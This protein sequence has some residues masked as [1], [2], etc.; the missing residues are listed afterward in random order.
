MYL[1]TVSTLFL[2][3]PLL[4]SASSIGSLTITRPLSQQYPPVGRVDQ[5]F[6]WTFSN[7]TFSPSNDLTYTAFNLPSWLSF[8]GSTCTFTGKPTSDDIGNNRLV[9]ITAT[10]IDG[11][12]TISD[13]IDLLVSEHENKIQIGHAISDQLFGNNTSTS[14]TPSKIASAYPYNNV[15]PYYPGV[16]VP[17]NWSFSLGFT[18]STFTAPTRVFYSASLI[19]GSPLPDWLVFNNQTVTFDGVSPPDS[20]GQIYRIILSGSDTFDYSDIQQSF[21]VVISSHDIQQTTNMVINMTIGY[22]GEVGLKNIL[23]NSL[24]LNGQQSFD[25]SELSNIQVDTTGNGWLTYHS[26]NMSISGTPSSNQQ[27]I[28]L[29]ISITDKYDDILNTTIQVALFPS[30]FKDDKPDPMIIEVGKLNNISLTQFLSNSTLDNINITTTFD[31]KDAGSWLSLSPDQKSLSGIPPDDTSYDSV[32]AMLHA[33]DLTTNAYSKSVL[34]FSLFSN[35]TWISHT[36]PHQ[37][38]HGLSK[39]TQVAIGIVCSLVGALLLGFLLLQCRRRRASSALA[40]GMEDGQYT[41]SPIPEEGKWS[42][43]AA[44]T[45]ALEYVEKMG[46]DPATAQ[47]LVLGRIDGG[48]SETVVNTVPHLRSASGASSTS[49]KVKKSFLSNPF[50]KGNKR[51]LPKISNPIIMPSLSNAAFQAQLAAAVDKAGIVDRSQTTYSTSTQSDHNDH[52]QDHDRSQSESEFTATPSYI[53]AS[54]IDRSSNNGSKLSQR[55]DM[56]GDQS[57]LSIDRSTTLTDDSKFN[58]GNTTRSGQSSR[59]SWESEPPFIWTTGDTPHNNQDGNSSFR[60]SSRSSSRTNETRN[61]I[62]STTIDPNAPTQRSDFKITNIPIIHSSKSLNKNVLMTRSNSPIDSLNDNEGISIDN[63]HFPTDSDLAHTETS[64]LSGD[65]PNSGVIIQTASRVDARRTLDSPAAASLASSHTER[66]APSPVMTTHS[67]LVSFGKQRNVQVEQGKGSMSHSAVIEAGSIGLGIG[68]G[69]SH[70]VANAN[71]ASHNQTPPTIIRK[72]HTPS[73]PPESPLPQPP[74]KAITRPRQSGSSSSSRSPTP[75]TSLPSLPAL[76]TLPSTTSTASKK[77]KPR[78]ASP[79][80]SPQRI[81]LGVLEPFHFYPPLSIS[82]SNSTS[83]T[84]SSIRSGDV[85]YLAFVE[86]KSTSQRKST[87]LVDLPDWLHFEDGELWGVPKQQDRGEVDIRI[88]E[89]RGETERV[90]GR[91]SLEVVGR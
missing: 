86:K 19:D 56:T 80:A 68:I 14:S 63:I 61:S 59:A 32:S 18:P 13:Y 42:Y 33:Q 79:L 10:T 39:G 87:E 47:M 2:F 77:S 81:L 20:N 64:S 66:G 83:T 24:T 34:T 69:I 58:G 55:S 16:R 70:V 57:L 29:P 1:S 50:A 36:H 9:Q 71:G 74:I 31:P 3:L 73:P 17:P 28:A 53:S 4:I 46:G 65:D 38:S 5:S 45:P 89:K 52:E 51:I 88:I 90:V 85:E 84:A 67:R 15:S 12:S 76:P 8:Q 91:F 23:K 72:L 35:D 26:A 62:L 22:N 11:Q 43:E 40:R 49:N 30:V 41:T 27:S 25:I 7:E 75:P 60:S 21:T 6:T 82:P 48:S 54:Q 37:H 78:S 44:E